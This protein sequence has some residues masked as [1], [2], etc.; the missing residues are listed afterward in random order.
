MRRSPGKRRLVHSYRAVL[1]GL[2]LPLANYLVYFSTLTLPRTLLNTRVQLFSKVDFSPEAYGTALASPVMG[3]FLF[4]FDPQG[5]FLL[6]CNVSLAP[7]MGN[8]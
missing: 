1:P 3:R 4:L 6:M 2:C 5:A 8:V 7:R